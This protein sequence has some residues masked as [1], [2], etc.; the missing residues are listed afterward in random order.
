MIAANDKRLEGDEINVRYKAAF[1]YYDRNHFT[2]AAKR[3]ADIILK[4][5][6]D[7]QAQTAADLSLNILETKQEWEELAR[8]S[9][10]FHENK[11]LAKPG[12]KWTADLAK[13]MEG[14]QYKYIDIVVYN[15]NGGKQEKAPAKAAPMF[16]DFVKEFPKSQY[17]DQALRYSM[18]IYQEAKQLDQAIAVGE[19]I[20]QEYP[21]TK[22]RGDATLDLASF[23][24]QTS[25]FA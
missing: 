12:D 16:R 10:A 20:L 8:V 1:L 19:Q 3:F 25:D 18:V 13:I 7:K 17:A 4:W 24:Q 6:T 9:R 11:K 15:G 5:P 21:Q 22:F 14:A 23:Y 2:E